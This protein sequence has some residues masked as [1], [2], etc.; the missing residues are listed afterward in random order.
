MAMSRTRAGG[1]NSSLG[2]CLGRSTA[3]GLGP[4]RIIFPMVVRP[5]GLA[6]GQG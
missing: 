6:L 1:T 4:G 5:G 3:L 2:T